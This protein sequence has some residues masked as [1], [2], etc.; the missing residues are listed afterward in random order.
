MSNEKPYPCSSDGC[1]EPAAYIDSAGYACCALCTDQ[2]I[3]PTPKCEPGRHAVVRTYPARGES[4]CQDCG[5]S[6]DANPSAETTP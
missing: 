5:A 3:K 4:V 2:K 1:E 6:W